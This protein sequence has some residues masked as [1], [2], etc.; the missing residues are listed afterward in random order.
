MEAINDNYESLKLEL[1]LKLKNEYITEEQY[2]DYLSQIN[3]SYNQDIIDE[4]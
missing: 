1:E 3:V 4:R 2:W